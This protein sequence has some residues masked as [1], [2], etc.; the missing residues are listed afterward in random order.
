MILQ[1]PAPVTVVIV[2]VSTLAQQCV[3]VCVL[4]MPLAVAAV[5][6]R[7]ATVVAKGTALTPRISYLA[8]SR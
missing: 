1:R 8:S 2:A 3:Q 6:A 5:E 4:K 7:I